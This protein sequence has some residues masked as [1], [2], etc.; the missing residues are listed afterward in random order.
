MWAKATSKKYLDQKWKFVSESHI[1][2]AREKLSDDVFLDSVDSESCTD[3]DSFD[4]DAP[5]A[6]NGAPFIQCTMYTF[7]WM[8]EKLEPKILIAPDV[9]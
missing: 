1:V 8:V 7:S 2:N 4:S 3:S 6:D 5:H 9:P